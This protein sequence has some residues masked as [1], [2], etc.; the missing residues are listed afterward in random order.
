MP[1]YKNIRKDCILYC[2]Q[3][4]LQA[5]IFKNTMIFLLSNFFGRTHTEMIYILN[6]NDKYFTWEI[7]LHAGITCLCQDL[8]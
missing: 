7:A 5:K 2:L 4:S 3:K 1:R 8:A 6:L